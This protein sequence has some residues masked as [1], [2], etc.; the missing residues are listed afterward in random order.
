MNFGLP[1]IVG[2]LDEDLLGACVWIF[3]ELVAQVG[4]CV[5]LRWALLG[6]GPAKTGFAGEA[7]Q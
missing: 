5:L 6:R 1:A 7:Q 4:G 2:L 3:V